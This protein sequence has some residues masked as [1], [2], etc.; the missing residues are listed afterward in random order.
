M[1]IQPR[2]FRGVQIA[3]RECW[4]CK[5]SRVDQIV[6]RCIAE[7]HTSTVTVCATLTYGGDDRLTGEVPL[8]ARILDYGDVSRYLKRLRKN[9]PCRYVA[10][11]EY[12]D[13]YGRGHWHLILF[14]HTDPHFQYFKRYEEKHWPFGFSYFEPAIYEKMRYACS[15]V[16][17]N[18]SSRE[19][20]ER[21]YG[22]SRMPPLGREYFRQLAMKHVEA[23]LSPQDCFYSFADIK[24]KDGTL[25]KFLLTRR[26]REYYM[27]DFIN[28]WAGAYGNMLWPQSDIVDEFIDAE[29]ARLHCQP[30]DWLE[31]RRFAMSKEMRKLLWHGGD[32]EDVGGIARKV[33]RHERA[34]RP[35]RLEDRLRAM[36][37]RKGIG[38]VPDVSRASRRARDTAFHGAG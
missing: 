4:Q 19:N 9:V 16:L 23:G 11:G 32:L 21:R 27:L 1:C 34:M 29:C 35:D 20:A 31:E 37:N 33:S 12:G 30:G 36:G 3:C 13:R 6:G 22:A 7:A 25:K 14:C 38:Y 18:A 26:S 17:K 15:Y 8:N 24:K 28:A 5:E 10:C 2:E